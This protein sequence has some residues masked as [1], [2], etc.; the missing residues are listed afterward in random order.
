LLG[1]AGNDTLIGGAGEDTLSGG[2]GRD[3][4]F[5][6][7]DADVFVFA[8][9][10]DSG[11]SKAKRDQIMDFQNGVDRIDLSHIDADIST[12]G[13]DAFIYINGNSITTPFAAFTGTAGELRT[14][15]TAGCYV[16]EGDVNGDG[17]ADFAI[18][19]VD[20]TFA[21]VLTASDFV[22]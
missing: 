18:D 21:A 4:L 17:K 22:L 7:A 19:L 3:I 15:W 16:I 12:S 1:L 9:I 14:V 8:S 6:G 10:A 11:L 2:I 20:S 13:D 5:G